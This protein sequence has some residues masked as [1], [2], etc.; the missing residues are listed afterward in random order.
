M[1]KLRRYTNMLISKMGFAEEI[2]GIRINY[3]PLLIGEET[4]VLD[5]RDGR[6]KRLGDKKPLSDEELRTL[7]EDIIQAIESGK[8]ELYLTLT[9]GEDVGPPL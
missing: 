8:V 1:E 3:L 6:I 5:R 9:F 4:I 7:E 2:Y